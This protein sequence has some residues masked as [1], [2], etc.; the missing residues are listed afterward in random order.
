MFNQ[1]KIWGVL[2]ND[3]RDQIRK[4]YSYHMREK[5]R[6]SQSAVWNESSMHGSKAQMLIDLFGK[7]NL[8]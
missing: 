2:D 7:H 4:T 3:T 8:M 1:D 5:E 6:L